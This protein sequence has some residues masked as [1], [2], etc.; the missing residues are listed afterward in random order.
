[1]IA[2][3]GLALYEK[4]EAELTPEVLR[5]IERQI[6][7]QLID[8]RWR[9]HLAE[10]DDLRNGINLRA[11]GQR[12]P[13]IEWQREGFETFADMMTSLNID[14]VRY[15]MHVQ[16]VRQPAVP[17]VT[18]ET[19]AAVQQPDL[20]GLSSGDAPAEAPDASGQA[21][22]EAAAPE[23][24]SVQMRQVAARPTTTNVQAAKADAASLTGR[25]SAP[26]EEPEKA[27][28]IVKDEWDK[29]PRNAPCPCGSGKKFK[30]CHGR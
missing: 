23:V 27:K 4:R 18:A 28:P 12:D 16:V 9:E 11:M 26:A 19:A 24:E 29:T 1:M 6:M 21:Q 5:Q 7:L 25:G 8:Q 22:A 15:V 20:A 30:S 13:L 17:A 10:M 3:E 14:F 2:A